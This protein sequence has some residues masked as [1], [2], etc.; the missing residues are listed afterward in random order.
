MTF[1]TQLEL[2]EKLRNS[3]N[4]KQLRDAPDYEGSHSTGVGTLSNFVFQV[5]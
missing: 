2:G 1:N 5:K 3:E 4:Q